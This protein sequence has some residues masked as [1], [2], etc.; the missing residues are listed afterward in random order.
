M[1]ILMIGAAVL[2]LGACNRGAA[3]NSVAN[4]VA[5]AANTAAAANSAAAPMPAAPA[6]AAAT[7]PAGFPNSDAQA[8]AAECFV[9]LGL[10]A[11]A[12]SQPGGRD[13]VILEQAANQWKAQLVHEGG[14][15]EAE[16]DQLI[17]SSVNPLT[18]TP[19]AQRDAAATWCF[20]NAPEV[21]PEAATN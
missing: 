11:G 7:L 4:A 21:D 1:R 8:K 14:M 10:A 6:T 9:Y 2:A 15:S 19:A 20:D 18:A 5:P 3:N 12:N 17:A 13:N 16:A